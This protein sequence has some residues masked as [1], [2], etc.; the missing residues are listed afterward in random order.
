MDFNER[1]KQLD[2]MTLEE[3]KQEK[4]KQL[5]LFLKKSEK[6]N[7]TH[8]Q[9]QELYEDFLLWGNL[10]WKIGFRSKGE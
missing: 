5:N 6:F 1:L 4:E 2:N 10:N 3:L 7:L 9:R 8:F